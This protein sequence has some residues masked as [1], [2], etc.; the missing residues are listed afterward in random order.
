MYESISFHYSLMVYVD[1]YNDMYTSLGILFPKTFHMLNGLYTTCLSF[2]KLLSDPWGLFSLLIFLNHLCICEDAIPPKLIQD[3]TALEWP[4]LKERQKE[5]STSLPLS[6]IA[7]AFIRHRMPAWT[8]SNL[9]LC[10]EPEIFCLLFFEL[11]TDESKH[12][13]QFKLWGFCFSGGFFFLCSNYFINH[14]MLLGITFSSIPFLL[15]LI[16]Q[17]HIYLWQVTHS[18]HAFVKIR[19]TVH[20]TKETKCINCYEASLI[21]PIPFNLS[22]GSET[23]LLCQGCTNMKQTRI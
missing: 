21:L 23:N 1:S 14:I 18:K 13:L 22:S 4:P 15:F 5:V 3:F 11:P 9:A 16:L 17:E 12:M 20:I 19:T 7:A 6:R 2:H 10:H 8:G